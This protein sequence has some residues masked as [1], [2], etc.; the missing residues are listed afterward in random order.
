MPSPG[1]PDA[2]DA[3][4][5]AVP[6]RLRVPATT[7]TGGMRSV[8][9]REHDVRGIAR[10]EQDALVLEWSGTTTVSEVEG[11]ATDVRSEPFPAGRRAVPLT[12]VRSIRRLGWWWRPRV[13][14]QV[15]E[16]DALAG[17]PA[18]RGPTLS[19]DLDRDDVPPAGRLVV[20][21]RATCRRLLSGAVSGP[22]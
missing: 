14:L 12:A 8:T 21:V 2:A 10:I 4:L 1:L 20:A 6:F 22:L 19:L 17:V 3:S 5:P 9:S 7:R 18:A 11:F 13:E 16:L 15:R